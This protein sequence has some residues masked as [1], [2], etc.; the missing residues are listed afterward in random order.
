MEFTEKTCQTKTVYEGKIL[1]LERDDVLLPGG[2]AGVRE[3]VRHAGGAC[4]LYVKDGKVALVRQFRYPYQE[5]LLELP[6][7]KLNRGEDPLLAAKRE[8]EE[9]TG[10]IAKTLRPLLTLYPSPG[11]SDE[12]IYIYEATETEEGEQHLD[13]DEFLSVSYVPLEEAYEMIKN[14]EIRDAKTIAGLLFKRLGLFP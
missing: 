1:S 6:A 4:V 13:E 9:E 7:G 12:K 8:L 10:V 3:V 2:K 11:Y 14:G 5:E